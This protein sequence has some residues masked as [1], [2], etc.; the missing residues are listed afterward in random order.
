LFHPGNDREFALDSYFFAF[1]IWVD[2]QRIAAR[3]PPNASSTQG[4]IRRIEMLDSQQTKQYERDGWTACSGFLSKQEVSEFLGDIENIC[5]GNTREEHD[6]A[7]LEMEPNQ[8]PEG[9]QVR[10]IY[11]PCTYYSRFRELSVSEKLLDRVQQLV[12]PNIIFHYSKI[13]MKPPRIGSVVEWHQDLSYYPLTNRDSLAVLFYLDDADSSN[14]CLQVISGRH[15]RPLMNHSR[16]QIFRGKITEPIGDSRPVPIEGSAGTAIFMHGMTPHASTVNSSLHPRRTLI[17]SYR[18]AD[19]FPIYFGEMTVKNEMHA[20]LVRGEQPSV[21]R[22]SASALPV[23]KYPGTIASL[24][25]LQE[26]SL[27]DGPRKSTM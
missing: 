15:T 22:F 7:R 4:D 5:Q 9:T 16:D 23:P 27:N 26:L 18:A 17:L 21:P 19:A 10:R 2:L 25:E 13:N 3:F 6:K 14:G 11:E 12:G 1:I 24:Y 20:R 8:P